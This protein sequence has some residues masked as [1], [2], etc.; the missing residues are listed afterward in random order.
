MWL[1]LGILSLPGPDN[2]TAPLEQHRSSAAPTHPPVKRVAM[3][4]VI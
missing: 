2:R 3:M 4:R 1:E